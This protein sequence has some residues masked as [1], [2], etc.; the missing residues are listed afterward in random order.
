MIARADDGVARRLHQVEEVIGL[1][2]NLVLADRN[3]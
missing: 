1:G 3:G 2:M